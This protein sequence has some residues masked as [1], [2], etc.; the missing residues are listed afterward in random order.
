MDVELI[1]TILGLMFLA[2]W[3]GQEHNKKHSKKRIEAIFRSQL[4]AKYPGLIE[5]FDGGY[6]SGRTA[7]FLWQPSG[8]AEV[9]FYDDEIHQDYSS[10]EGGQKYVNISVDR[11]LIANIEHYAEVARV[12]LKK[13]LNKRF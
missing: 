4:Y 1:F 2:A 11:D 12:D 3:W 8:Y 10:S 7:R 13:Y 5:T 6:R 9:I